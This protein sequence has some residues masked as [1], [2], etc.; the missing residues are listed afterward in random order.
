MLI[1]MQ[2]KATVL[3]PYREDKG[4]Y[5]EYWVQF[6]YSSPPPLYFTTGD[7]SELLDS[8]KDTKISGEELCVQLTE[9]L[10]ARIDPQW[11][12]VVVQGSGENVGLRVSCLKGKEDD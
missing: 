8:F 10:Y 4:A 5:D 9:K 2:S 1:E 11:V 3:C 12:E 7:F 6:E